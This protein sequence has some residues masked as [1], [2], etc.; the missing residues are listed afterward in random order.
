MPPI[1]LLIYNL[2]NRWLLAS[3][4]IGA[5]I[6]SILYFWIYNSTTNLPPDLIFFYS[7][8]YILTT[9]TLRNMGAGLLITSATTGFWEIPAQIYV[10]FFHWHLVQ[11]SGW[12]WVIYCT[13]IVYALLWS[14]RIPLRKAVPLIATATLVNASLIPLVYTWYFCRI[15]IASTLTYLI[16]KYGEKGHRSWFSSKS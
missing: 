16:L 14:A 11:F 10:Y 12:I 9:L 3:S 8:T 2:K 1:G 6:L 4:I 13:V 7:A 5:S 15:L